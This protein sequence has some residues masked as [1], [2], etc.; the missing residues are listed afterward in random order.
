MTGK[1]LTADSISRPSS[2][3]DTEL[4]RGRGGSTGNPAV[5]SVIKTVTWDYPMRS[6]SRA[7]K[8]LRS[9]SRREAS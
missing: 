5:L 1:Q 8:R 7:S 3:K 6:S 9:V 4:L 2:G